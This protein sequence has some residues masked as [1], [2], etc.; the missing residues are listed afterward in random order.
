MPDGLEMRMRTKPAWEYLKATLSNF[1]KDRVLELS[2]A[3]AYYAIFSIGPLLVLAIGVASLAMGRQG[4]QHQVHSQ[5]GG[6]LGPKTASMLDSMMAASQAGG[7]LVATIVGAVG[8]ALGATG[9]FVQL[10][11]SLNRVWG[12]EQK[13]SA[14]IWGYLLNRGLS[15]LM[16]L[17]IGLLL[18]VS[19]VLSAF[20]SSL[21][22]GTGLPNWVWH[23]C[24]ELLWFGLI[25]GFFALIFKY[26]P[27]VK[28]KWRDVW[29]GALVTSALFVIG[30]YLLGLYLGSIGAK[31]AY[32]AASSFV[33]FLMFVYYAAVIFLTGAEFTKVQAEKTGS[34]IVPSK[35]AIPLSAAQQT[36]EDSRQTPPDEQRKAA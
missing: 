17:G 23:I 20:I 28:I 22:G 33:V 34:E 13:P 10:Q 8:L 3:L 27:L 7:G 32:G 12:V 4:A 29:R 5:L 18:V 21:A 16:V 35:Y 26:L 25:A 15:L 36:G 30:K 1:S 24:N 14:G 19:M 6:I 31:S 2:A 11:Q 9:I